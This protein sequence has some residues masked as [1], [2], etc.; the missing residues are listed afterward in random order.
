MDSRIVV[1][2]GQGSVVEARLDN[3]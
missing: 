3:L 1:A 2:A